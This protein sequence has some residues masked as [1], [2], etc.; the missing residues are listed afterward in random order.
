MLGRSE[1]GFI[2]IQTEVFRDLL[3]GLFDIRR[4]QIDLVDHRDQIQI[5]LERQI[6][7]GDRLGFDTLRCIDQQQGTLTGHERSA[8]LVREVDMAGSVD[9]IETIP[10]AVL[11]IVEQRHGVALD[12]DSPL[13]FDVHRVQDLIAELPVLDAPQR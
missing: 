1:D 3:A 6:E 13:P 4:G 9:Q 10:L 11:G 12:G 7:V 8:D 5:V 2:G